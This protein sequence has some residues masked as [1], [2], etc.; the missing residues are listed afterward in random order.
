MM[1]A[2]ATIHH[3]ASASSA[4]FA[5]NVDD[6]EMHEFVVIYEGPPFPYHDDDQNENHHDCQNIENK[7][8][9]VHCLSL[10]SAGTSTN[11]YKSCVSEDDLLA[12]LSTRI[13]WPSSVLCISRLRDA[14]SSSSSSS[15]S[16]S[17]SPLLVSDVDRRRHP[18]L[19][20]ASIVPHLSSIRGGKGGFGT[21][22]RGQSKQAGARTTVDFGACR[23][24][25]GRRLRHVND[26]IKLRLW[27]DA[28][29]ALERG[30]ER[31]SAEAELAALK[32][33]SGIRNWH[34]AVPG[35]SEHGGVTSTNKGRRK[36]E[37]QLEN[38]ARGYRAREEAAR[39]LLERRKM[40]QEIAISEYVRRMETEGGRI[41]TISGGGGETVKEG[42]L[43]HYRRRREERGGGKQKRGVGDGDYADHGG[44]NTLTTAVSKDEE[45]DARSMDDDAVAGDTS[46]ASAS[47]RYLITLSGEM[48][49]FDIPL[50]NDMVK[51]G[52]SENTTPITTT[53]TAKLRIQ[54]QS[55]F[56]TAVIL[57]D[58]EKTMEMM[59]GGS[60]GGVYV[61]YTIRTA[62]LAQ[63]GWA[64][65][66]GLEV[67]A[68][69]G[70]AG[71]FV[72]N[73]D[74]GDGVGDDAASYGYDGSRG[75]KFHGGEEVAY[76][77]TSSSGGEGGGSAPPVEWKAGDVL[78]CYCK[79]SESRGAEDAG[80]VEI[81]YSLNGIDLGGAFVVSNIDGE[82]FRFYPAVSLNLNEVVDVNIG[83][84]FAHFDPRDGCV[85]ACELV[86]NGS[87]EV[88]DDDARV[89]YFCVGESSN[90]ADEDGDP[91]KKRPRDESLP[92]QISDAATGRISANEAIDVKL[93]NK[94]TVS[95]DTFD[96]NK[97]SSVDELKDLGSERLKSIM[98]LMGVK[99][100]GTLDERAARLFSLKG[101]RR[102]Q[103]PTKVRG[104]NF[105]Q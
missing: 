73:S 52:G 101:L 27:R 58:S 60:I 55:D 84:D 59:R 75:L 103:Y 69:G 57:L 46:S 70:A 4:S 90:Q 37:R 7:N 42:I 99:C 67:D 86:V 34:L 18:V 87:I 45:V 23:D 56:A 19:L 17:S 32:T 49:A 97:Y 16:S 88:G 31:A 39:D 48:S 82:A 15:W 91:P 83:P 93:T 41:S 50:D 78:G 92:G 81:G 25:S 61:E 12:S 96:L 6:R 95:S 2:M 65:V 85:G 51:V 20:R 77:S 102:D 10:P 54:S 104:K 24:L 71:T 80:V 98:L 100:G 21:L 66:G 3:S 62:G 14:S 68:S 38:E 64:R 89:G 9:Q 105:I 63:I 13:G 36:V 76:G 5:T 47:P 28:R 8:R 26:E 72:P 11:R 30:D 22:L 44:D 43:A 1:M 53:T 79:L 94:P 33:P 35:W 29:A 74:A 40:D